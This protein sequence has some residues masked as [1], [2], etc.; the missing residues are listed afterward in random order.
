MSKVSVII[1]VYN[2]VHLLRLALISLTQQSMLPDEVVIS[3]DGSDEYVIENIADL[4]KEFKFK[5]KYVGQANKGFRLAK[6]R[7]NG[8]RISEGDLLICLDQDLLYT[9]KAIETFIQNADK[10]KFVTS[11]PV[12]LTK[13]QTDKI[14]EES[15][16]KKEY[17]KLISIQQEK[18]IKNQF[19][20]DYFSF[21]LHKLGLSSRG[22]KLRGGACAIN[23]DDYFELNGYDEKFIGWGNEDDDFRRR[24]Y[25]KGVAG[26]NP[27]YDQFPIHLYHEPFHVNGERV[28]QDYTKTR[29]AEIKHG[30]IVCEEGVNDNKEELIIREL[31]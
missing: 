4:V 30:K 20:K 11:Y 1:T 27:F 26:F 8:A 18:K 12:R 22:P 14:N 17:L 10:D 5:M 31:N 13:E 6:C 23:R 29:I 15:V 19:Y 2:R 16:K 7:N 28:N 3:D 25:Q 24:L 9:D 21:V